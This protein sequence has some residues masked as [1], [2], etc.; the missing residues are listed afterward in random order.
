MRRGLL[1]MCFGKQCERGFQAAFADIAPRADDVAD[2]IDADGLF[3][4]R[5]PV[6]AESYKVEVRLAFS[7]YKYF[8]AQ[9]G[10]GDTG[11]IGLTSRHV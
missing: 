8:L 9:M 5:A 11:G 10:T 2:D 3:V 7:A 4:H 6:L 1:G